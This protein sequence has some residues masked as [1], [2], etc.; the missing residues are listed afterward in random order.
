MLV[1]ISIYPSLLSNNYGILSLTT[2]A[3]LVEDL[4]VLEPTRSVMEQLQLSPN[5]LINCKTEIK[6]QKIGLHFAWYL[7]QRIM[8]KL[9]VPLREVWV[10]N[11]L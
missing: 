3:P 4:V 9:S 8:I 1:S 5:T 6:I 10:A 2:K 11:L 7:H